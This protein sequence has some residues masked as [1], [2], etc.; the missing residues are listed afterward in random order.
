MEDAATEECK[1]WV[2]KYVT[3]YQYYQY[4]LVVLS[5][6]E[7]SDVDIDGFNQK[8]AFKERLNRKI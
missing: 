2:H 6:K 3:K 1:D 5:A 4:L 8:Y 7:K